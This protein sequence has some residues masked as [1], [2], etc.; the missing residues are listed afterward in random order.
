[1]TLIIALPF[2]SYAVRIGTGWQWL[3]AVFFTFIPAISITVTLV[4][5]LV[6]H[7][8]KPCTLPKLDFLQHGIP[9]ECR[10]MVVIPTLLTHPAEVDSLLK[11]LE[12]HY[13]RNP[14]PQL[15]F[16]LLTDFADVADTETTDATAVADRQLLTQTQNGIEALNK[17]Y[18]GQPFYF[19]HRHRQWNPSE[20][21]RMGWERKRGKLHEFNQLLRGRDQTS[22]TV[23]IGNLDILPHIQYI[24]TL[25]ADTILPRD[26]ANR[27]I[28]ALAHPLNQPQFEPHTSKVIAGY[29]ILQPRTQIQST[30]ANYFF[31]TRIFAGDTG[32]DL[33]T[34]AVSDVYQDLFGEGSCIGKGIYHVDAF[35]RSLAG[36]IPEN[37]LLSH[38]LF[39]GIYGR[40]GLVTDI[41][42]YEEFIGLDDNWLPPI[43]F[44][45]RP[46][47]WS[48]TARLPPTSGFICCSLSPPTTWVILAPDFSPARLELGQSS[49]IVRSY[50][51]HHQGM[52]LLALANYLH[53]N[54]KCSV[55][56]ET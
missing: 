36:R 12:L 14:D 24:I 13:L 19:F 10:T 50:M 49:A 7:L 52:I 39:E 44:K 17:R 4:N 23:Q 18:A 16:A 38:D 9:P 25:D 31:F 41:V 34:L 22:F 51:A 15:S 28:G 43:I 37:T 2:I 29:T 47:A 11:Q 30:S 3:T 53:D 21:T 1:M 33:Y 32:L 8:I 48:L 6:T 56:Q 45:R 54:R 42:L 27:L 40:A 5:W 26:G 35:E 20:N 55:P 46:A